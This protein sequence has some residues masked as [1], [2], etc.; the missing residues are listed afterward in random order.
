M[1][2][3]KA[4]IL[5]HPSDRPPRHYCQT[6]LGPFQYASLSGYDPFSSVGA[7]M[8]RREFLGFL[9]GVALWPPLGLAVLSTLLARNDQAIE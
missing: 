3:S 8:K 2:L 1:G 6:S 7:C 4:L 5:M 9:G